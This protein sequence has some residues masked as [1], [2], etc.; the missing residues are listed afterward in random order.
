M[1]FDWGHLKQ[2]KGGIGNGVSIE[3]LGLE[4]WRDEP[5]K[6]KREERK[7]MERTRRE[8]R[9]L[10]AKSLWFLSLFQAF[11]MEMAPDVLFRQ[12]VSI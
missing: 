4:F 1:G 3:R 9:V 10:G 2:S 8:I 6:K 11:A 5:E 12:K 7:I